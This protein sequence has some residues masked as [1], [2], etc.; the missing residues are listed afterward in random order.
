MRHGGR[1]IANRKRDIRREAAGRMSDAGPLRRLC[2]L[3]DLTEGQPLRAEIAGYAPFAV[4]LVGGQCY[5][6]D[7]TCTHG[8]AS[9]ADEGELDGFTIV[10]TWHDGAFDIR[11]GAVKAI[12]CTE[13]IRTYPAIVQDGGVHIIMPAD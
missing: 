6:T 3:D 11:T 2:H 8:K 13:P 9:L 5:V 10:C 7:D 12:P 4:Y 1:A